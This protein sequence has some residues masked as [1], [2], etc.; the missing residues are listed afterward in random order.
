VHK[1]QAWS[2][3]GFILKTNCLKE[4]M[5][6][7]TTCKINGVKIS[8]DSEGKNKVEVIVDNV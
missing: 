1:G 3:E 7:P 4:N 6:K 5:S 2:Q 8:K